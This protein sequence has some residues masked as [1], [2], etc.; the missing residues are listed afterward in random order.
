MI[1]LKT[2]SSILLSLN[3]FQ[4]GSTCEGKVDFTGGCCEVFDLNEENEELPNN[5]AQILLKANDRNSLNCCAIKPDT[6]VHE[7]KTDLGLVKGHAYSITK[8]QENT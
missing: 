4:G 8:V 7:L 2:P 3:I 6:E 5:L 1:K